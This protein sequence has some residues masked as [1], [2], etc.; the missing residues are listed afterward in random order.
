MENLHR[1]YQQQIS[2]TTYIKNSPVPLEQPQIQLIQNVADHLFNHRN[3]IDQRPLLVFVDGKAGSGKTVTL[4][5][6]RKIFA[7]QSSLHLLFIGSNSQ[8]VAAI[9]G[10]HHIEYNNPIPHH[11]TNEKQYFII[12]ESQAC[13]TSTISCFG[14]VVTRLGADEYKS[15]EFLAGKNIV[16]FGHNGG[17]KYR[18]IDSWWTSPVVNAF[19]TFLHFNTCKTVEPSH[20]AHLLRSARELFPEGV[21][22]FHHPKQTPAEI[23]ITPWPFMQKTWNDEAVKT[24]ASSVNCP[25]HIS[26]SIDDTSCDLIQVN[27]KSPSHSI[28][29]SLGPP[30]TEVSICMGMPVAIVAGKWSGYWGHVA[31]IGS[32]PDKDT[33]EWIRVRLG[34]EFNVLNPT[35]DQFIT[36]KAITLQIKHRS[37]IRNHDNPI[38]VNRY[39]IPVMPRYALLE[40]E[41]AGQ[42]FDCGFVDNCRGLENFHSLSFVLSR[43]RSAGGI[44]MIEPYSDADIAILTDT[45]T[46]KEEDRLS[47]ILSSRVRSMGLV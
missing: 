4:N 19:T 26:R 24:F 47:D 11:I 1:Q 9:S 29:S 39:Q 8:P 7:H 16:V 33:I 30:Y 21:D 25:L 22:Y 31:A 5:I 38:V 41:A 18:D 42:F 13:A 12:D 10:G 17:W 27:S 40:A 36:I 37:R 46:V 34:N 15:W 14:H 3:G 35:I 32:E 20:H 23:L 6:I 44:R 2:V 43:F 28:L 45:M